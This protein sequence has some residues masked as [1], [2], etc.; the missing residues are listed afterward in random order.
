M[1]VD[2]SM[3]EGVRSKFDSEYAAWTRG[4]SDTEV[5]VDTTLIL[6]ENFETYSIINGFAPDEF[7][8]TLSATGETYVDAIIANRRCFVAN[9]SMLDPEGNGT[10]D[11]MRM[12]D[13]IMYTPPGKFDTFPRSFFIDVIRGD[14][15]EYTALAYYADRLLAFKK[16]TLYIVNIASPSP[17]NWFLENTEISKGVNYPGAVWT[18]TRGVFWANHIG[19]FYYNGSQ[20]VDL[21]EG[22]L[23]KD[24]SLSGPSAGGNAQTWTGY[25]SYLP[26]VYYLP[27]SN[28]LF[29]KNNAFSLDDR[30]DNTTLDNLGTWVYSFYTGAWTRLRYDDFGAEANYWYGNVVKTKNNNLYCGGFSQNLQTGS[31]DTTPNQGRFD[32]DLIASSSHTSNTQVVLTKD[33]DF[34]NPARVKKVYSVILTYRSRDAMTT[35]VSYAIDGAEDDGDYTNFTGNFADTGGGDNL[36]DWAQVRVTPASPVECQSMK[37]RVKNTAGSTSRFDLNDISIEY[38]ETY[39]R[40]S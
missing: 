10:S 21:T 13:R 6:D 37:I 4:S 27:S 26:I 35:P 15:D 18:D 19:I 32:D 9:V 8:N 40:V 34:G 30:E 11:L 2:I 24:S 14:A 31:V 16:Q 23:A 38:R 1:L 17:S 12:R 20:I 28:M 7:K 25:A 33:I 29:V 3:R 39:K 22:K 36:D 5:Y